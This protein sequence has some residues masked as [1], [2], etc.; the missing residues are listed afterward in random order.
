MATA[1]ILQALLSPAVAPQRRVQQTDAPVHSESW[2]NADASFRAW[3]ALNDE[4]TRRSV[5]AGRRY[6][7]HLQPSDVMADGDIDSTLALFAGD[8]IMARFALALA[9]RKC[10]DRKEFFEACEFFARVRDRLRADDGVGI[11]VD[12]AGGHGLVGTLA[13]LLKREQFPKVIVRDPQRPPSFDSVVAAAVEVAPWMEGRV[14]F[15][16]KKVGGLNGSLP[17]GCAVVGI[18]ACGG[19]TDKVIA[20]AVA[21][22][23]RTIALMPCCYESTA[24]HAPNAL[25]LALGVPLA[26]DIHRTYTLEQLGYTVAWKSIPLSISPMNRILLARRAGKESIPVVDSEDE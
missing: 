17:R 16:Q 8:S 1:I 10:I 21:A 3:P 11:L 19:L 24:V 20:A 25:R 15:E 9:A 26:A 6:R 23:A 2:R 4:A 12:A 14:S 5:N 22:D 7:L 13:A 18:H